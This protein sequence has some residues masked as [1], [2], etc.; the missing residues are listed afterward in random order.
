MNKKLITAVILGLISAQATAAIQYEFVNTN[1]KFNAFGVDLSDNNNLLLIDKDYN[2]SIWD[3]V[4]TTETNISNSSIFSPYSV[5]DNGAL[6]GH[7]A[8]ENPRDAAY[9]DNGVTLNMTPS[10]ASSFAS[11]LNNNGFIAA[12]SNQGIQQFQTHA[13]LWDTTTKTSVDLGT[14]PGGWNSVAFSIND[15]NQVVGFSQTKPNGMIEEHAF[16]WNDGK[17]IDLGGLNGENSSRA[18]DINNNGQI[19]GSS[20]DSGN[21]PNNQ[22][23]WNVNGN[24]IDIQLITGASRANAINDN[25]DVVGSSDG[26]FAFL[27]NDGNMIDLNTLIDPNLISAGWSL[28]NAFDINNAGWIIGDANNH[29]TGESTTFLLNPLAPIPE[30][31]TWAMLL[32]GLG[33]L[34]FVGRKRNTT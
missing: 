28:Y 12:T 13:T 16:L 6:A 17:M 34:G 7:V 15:H 19:L 33:L 24:D 26:G 20:S 3:G 32:S 22:V 29:I 1:D 8:L 31:T 4:K 18:I 23:I 25:G 2:I 27:W 5:N 10:G 21:A 11:D 14:L 9:W 30:P